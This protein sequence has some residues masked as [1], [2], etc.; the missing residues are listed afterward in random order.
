MTLL[1]LQ[2]VL[3]HREVM[4]VVN[5]QP[6]GRR[7]DQTSGVATHPTT[8]LSQKGA[9]RHID[10]A[11]LS[12]LTGNV[13]GPEAVIGVVAHLETIPIQAA[14]EVVVNGWMDTHDGVAVKINDLVDGPLDDVRPSQRAGALQGRQILWLRLQ[15]SRSQSRACTSTGSVADV[16]SDSSGGRGMI[17][18]P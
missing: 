5:V 7:H 3:S 4:V 13:L 10:R 1:K 17:S 9:A 2:V 18:A 12:V 6:F 11:V 14:A 16:S 15:T 8:R